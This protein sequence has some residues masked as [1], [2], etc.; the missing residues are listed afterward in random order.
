[1]T[2]LYGY[3]TKETISSY[4]PAQVKAVGLIMARVLDFS[5]MI[6]SVIL[7]HNYDKR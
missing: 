1:M 6:Y 2:K 4:T 7:N 5:P 3:N